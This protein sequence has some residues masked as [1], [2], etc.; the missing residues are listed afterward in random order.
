MLSRGFSC[1]KL[2]DKEKWAEQL[3]FCR[4][5]W[6]QWDMDFC[7]ILA[8]WGA[9]L[10]DHG[11]RQNFNRAPGHSLYLEGDMVRGTVL[12]T[13]IV[14]EQR[15][16]RT[17]MLMVIW[18]KSYI[19]LDEFS[20]LKPRLIWLSPPVSPQPANNRKLLWAPNWA[21]S[22]ESISQCSGSRW[23][24]VYFFHHES[25]RNLYS[26]KSTPWIGNLQSK[27]FQRDSGLAMY[28]QWKGLLKSQ[29]NSTSLGGGAVLSVTVSAVKQD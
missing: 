19:G 10:K 12:H 16:G 2:V 22:S 23:I 13:F 17:H 21:K 7:S 3:T 25:N 6:Y 20:L 14:S 18:G 5:C 1:F 24:I 4:I 27:E 15:L 8:P 11:K 29:L 26:L 28:F 9:A